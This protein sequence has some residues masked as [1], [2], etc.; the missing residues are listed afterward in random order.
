MTLRAPPLLLI[1]KPH[2]RHGRLEPDVPRPTAS[3]PKLEKLVDPTRLERPVALMLFD[4]RI[5]GKVCTYWLAITV[6]S[7][8]TAVNRE[9]SR[10]N[11]KGPLRRE[12]SRAPSA[13]SETDRECGAR[14]SGAGSVRYWTY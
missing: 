8:S 1:K 4:L 5:N 10:M 11:N 2:T 12:K 6:F 7:A 13:A 3:R 9:L 14:I